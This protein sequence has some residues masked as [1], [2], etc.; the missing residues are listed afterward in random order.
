MPIEIKNLKYVYYAHTPFEYEALKNINLT[1]QDKSFTAIIGHTGSGKSTLVQH[2][3][4]IL[5]PTD[6]EIRVNDY[7]IT[8]KTKVDNIKS[9]RKLVGMV[10]QFPEYQ[11]FEETVYKDIAFGP[12]NFG[13]T[14]EEL[15]PKILEILKLV[16]LDEK[17]LDVSPFDLSGGQRRRVAIAGILAMEP[18]ILVLDEPTS[19]LD[20][21]GAYEMMD[22]FKTLNEQGKTIIMVTHEMDYVLKY[23]NHAVVLRNGEVVI[24]DKPIN[25]FRNKELLKDI[26]IEEPMVISFANKLTAKGLK[27]NYDNIKDVESLS[28]EIIKSKGGK[29]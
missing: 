7:L 27:L 4:A 10:F 17:C 13:A 25:I 3:N 26:H 19:G 2:L 1:F 21:Q 11:L 16:G 9:L 18:E 6:G 28:N 12:K 20:P 22:L 5:K 8:S 15:K 29:K 24:E 23:C 14:D